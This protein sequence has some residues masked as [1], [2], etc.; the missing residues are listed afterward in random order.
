[1]DTTGDANPGIPGISRSKR[2]SL[3][4]GQ[5]MDPFDGAVEQVKAPYDGASLGWIPTM[6]PQDVNH[7]VER[8]V[9]ALRRDDFP[10]WRRVAVL[11]NAARALSEQ[12]EEFAVCIALESA[13]PIRTARLEVDRAISTFQFSAAVARQFAGEMVSL[14][15]AEM[16]EGK[17]GF[18][19]RVPVGVV[20]A[21]SSFNFP[22]NLV[23][24]KVAPAIA[25]GCPVVLKPSGQTPFSTVLL[26][27]LLIE[28]AG[29]PQDYLGVVTG[30]GSTVGTA[31]VDHPDVALISFTGSPE[32][33]WGIKARAPRKKVGLELG[34]NSPLIIEPSADWPSAIAKL[35]TAGYSH[36]G[37]SCVSTQRVYVHS[38]LM[39]DVMDALCEEVRSLVLGDPLGETT[40]VSSLISVKERDRVASW[41]GEA[42]DGG[43]E[44]TVG[45]IVREDGILTPSV[46]RNPKPAMKVCAEEVF[47]PVVCVM[48][49]DNFDD[50]VRLASDT[51]YGLQAAVYTADLGTALDAAKRLRFGGVLINEVPTWRADH[52]PYGGLRDSGNTREGPA[53]AVREMTEERLIVLSA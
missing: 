13:K 42:Q 48:S 50:A 22:L 35:R 10:A 41:L 53:W 40:E 20:G 29:L 7:V 52:Q 14:D 39:D 4:F 33:G 6:E 28:D 36:A 17:I 2:T 25:A 49:Y 44:L 30:P 19:L 21:I 47:G 24:H 37:Q 18:T 43:A 34:N 11:E 5:G 27:R 31:I 1:M 51:R 45:G 15:A 23:A 8:A 9:S 46:V 16:G 32:V 3:W 12:R 38:S 26:A